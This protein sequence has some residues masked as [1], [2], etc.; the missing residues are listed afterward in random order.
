MLGICAGL[1][2]CYHE[3]SRRLGQKSSPSLL[4]AFFAATLALA[5]VF[6]YSRA[7]TILMLCYLLVVFAQV[8]LAA[9]RL[10]HGSQSAWKT[11]SLICAVIAG[12]GLIELSI[13]P[14]GQAIERMEALIKGYHSEAADLRREEA[15]ATLDLARG[16]LAYGWGAGSFRFAF[17]AYQKAHPSLLWSE[18]HKSLFW[19]HAHND[20]A[21]LLSEL[22]I[23]GCSLIALGALYYSTT[24]I[25]LRIWENRTALFI[26]GGCLMILVHSYGDFN[27]YNP[28]V[29]I[30]WCACWPLLVRLLETSRLP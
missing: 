17:P 13:L 2:V 4:F 29:L 11:P 15:R 10:G 25:R 27:F 14:T 6:S 28:A 23:A 16:S 7:A 12:F 9:D 8:G 1:T 26:A 21:E 20:Y 30:T 3:R 19:E 18:Q 5:V 22:G 24:L